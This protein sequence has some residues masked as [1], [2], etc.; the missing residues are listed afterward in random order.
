[1]KRDLILNHFVRFEG[2]FNHF[3]L[4]SDGIV[5]FG[6]GSALFSE[7]D[8]LNLVLYNKRT[9]LFATPTEKINE[10]KTIRECAV[11]NK[12]FYYESFCSLVTTDEVVESKFFLEIDNFLTEL[13]NNFCR[14]D[15]FPEPAQLVLLDM[16]YNLGPQHLREFVK[17]LL[18][19]QARRWVD[20][21]AECHRIGISDERNDWAKQTLLS[22]VS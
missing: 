4:D 19:F 16:V 14:L 11:G 17:F 6:I 10:F 13:D 22:L 21:A 15:L 18:A 8:A 9:G 12:A 20:A 1:M 5:T 3:Y 2:R 7:Q